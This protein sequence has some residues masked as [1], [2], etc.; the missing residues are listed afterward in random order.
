M[1]INSLV[2]DQNKIVHFRAQN[3]TQLRLH[4]DMRKDYFNLRN[5]IK[6]RDLK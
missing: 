6:I 3:G 1:T 2:Q 5:G 4:R